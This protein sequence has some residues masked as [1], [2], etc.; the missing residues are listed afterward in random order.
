[1]FSHNTVCNF[2]PAVLSGLGSSNNVLF[3][4]VPISSIIVLW[5]RNTPFSYSHWNYIMSQQTHHYYYICWAQLFPYV[6]VSVTLYAFLHRNDLI[7]PN[8]SIKSHL[9]SNRLLYICPCCVW[10]A[11]CFKH[12]LYF[13]W[14]RLCP[15]QPASPLPALFSPKEKQILL[16]H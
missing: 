10:L 2:P 12:C 8:G 6:L 9:L 3:S 4:I 16:W 15:K 14:M 7:S 5:H 11:I 1:M 13:G